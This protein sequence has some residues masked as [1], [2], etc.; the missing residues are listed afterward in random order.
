MLITHHLLTPGE[1]PF[2][3]PAIT[4]ELEAVLTVPENPRWQ[5]VALLGHPHSLH[6]GTINNKVITTLVKV[7]K[8]LHIPSLRFNFRGVGH[9]TGVFDNGM[10]ESEDMLHIARQLQ[11]EIPNCK[12][13][14]AGFSFGSYVVYRAAA[15]CKHALLITLAPPVHHY[16][17]LE[18]SPP[19]A[20]WIVV[21]AEQDE[22]IPAKH[23][24]D[25]VVEISPPIYLLNFNDTSH[26]FHGKLM[27]LKT[28]L[29]D[30]IHNK[31][32]LHDAA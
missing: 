2:M 4:G 1:H 22:L 13:V 12:L 14:F 24:Q 10:G 27:E 32:L 3:I 15:Q 31:A 29:L 25:F 26:F 5:Y 28:R 17:Y 9:S 18:F 30:T 19:P 20:P 11:Q 21:A 8:E 6:G 7:F 16:D 23:I